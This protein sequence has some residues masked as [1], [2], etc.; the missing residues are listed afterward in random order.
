MDSLN[1]LK[2]TYRP[3]FFN[4][5]G[6]NKAIDKQGENVLECIQDCFETCA[7]EF[8]E[9]SPCISCGSSSSLDQV[10]CHSK[11][12]EQTKLELAKVNPV[13]NVFNTFNFLLSP[14]RIER[15][16]GSNLSEEILDEDIDVLF[17]GS[18]ALLG[19]GEGEGKKSCVERL[20]FDEEVFD[21][22][23][24]KNFSKSKGF[25]AGKETKKPTSCQ[26][27][28][29][30]SLPSLEAMTSALAV[31]N[32][33]K[34]AKP[35]EECEFLIE[36]SF[37]ASSASWISTSRKKQKP[38]KKRL[39]AVSFEENKEAQQHNE[40]RKDKRELGKTIVP[41]PVK[42]IKAT[43]SNVGEIAFDGLQNA[44]RTNEVMAVKNDQSQLAIKTTQETRKQMHSKNRDKDL[45][46]IRNRVY[47]DPISRKQAQDLIPLLEP[48]QR[49]S[50]RI[51]PVE[52]TK[53]SSSQC[54]LTT[55]T[56]A[57]NENQQECR[58]SVLS[59]KDCTQS[60]NTDIYSENLGSVPKPVPVA[61]QLCHST[62][63]RKQ[64][65][66]SKKQLGTPKKKKKSTVGPRRRK[67]RRSVSERSLEDD[68]GE[69]QLDKKD[70]NLHPYEL[71]KTDLRRA[72][73]QKV[74]Q[75]SLL[76]SKD[77][78]YQED[79][80]EQQHVAEKLLNAS[81]RQRNSGRFLPQSWASDEDM[82][83]SGP[84]CSDEI[85]TREWNPLNKD[86]SGSVSPTS[87][88]S[89]RRSKR[90]RT[91]PL[92]YWQ[93]ERVDYKTRA[94]DE[95]SE[96]EENLNG[97]KHKLV[98]PTNTPNVRRTKRIR[99]KPLE[100]WRGER[101]DYKTRASGGFVIGGIVSPEQREPRKPKPKV[102]RKSVP[103]MENMHDNSVSLRDPS[104]PAVVF[105]K[106]SN[107]EVLLQC[108]NNGSSH[109]FFIGNEAVSI[110]KYLSTPSFSVGKMILK[111]LKEKGYQYSHTD[112]L[113]F[114]ISCGKLLLTLYDQNYC[115]TAGNYFFIPPGNIYNIRNLWNKECVILFTQLKGK[116]QKSNL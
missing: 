64:K 110:Y 28:M 33:A 45:V 58:V 24:S 15:F 41:T 99:I 96:L 17:L 22:H 101:V 16:S 10:P 84:V 72:T 76:K 18:P 51:Q 102:T 65:S 85:F 59:S 13:N 35:E 53:Q 86:A 113:V 115:L 9:C 100:Y 68:H 81:A 34:G 91:K 37:G 88:S 98:W 8:T 70:K 116:G 111:P 49:L 50:V 40:R 107:Q 2:T 20:C 23:N 78:K 43:L 57:H 61:Q 42:Q 112:T 105:D 109:V 108:V 21:L 3:R 6:K 55:L 48:E 14:A 71:R 94:S 39:I 66:S 80:C 104:Q 4:R 32:A 19:E 36:E 83:N 11:K 54:K 63:I 38:Q 82:N 114:H 7:K 1:H 52:S 62:P 93:G 92:E 60:K 5:E 27:K 56:E 25:C 87:T 95:S 103:E 31:R 47:Q 97:L 75:T 67:S 90:I 73:P 74:K 44:S 12:K 79:S 26:I 29:S 77:N 69:E 30:R 89:V 106:A 46:E